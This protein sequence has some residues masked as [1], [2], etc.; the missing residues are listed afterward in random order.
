MKLLG[1]LLLAI[2]LG[3]AVLKPNKTVDKGSLETNMSEIK[4]YTN[5]VLGE[6]IEVIN[7][8]AQQASMEKFV[9]AAVSRVVSQISSDAGSITREIS[10]T[11]LVNQLIGT[12]N[13][14]PLLTQQQFKNAVCK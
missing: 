2:F 7:K 14:L 9:D 3:I 1:I 13:N 5:R 6:S 4:N 8:Q 11:I 10:G 12:Y